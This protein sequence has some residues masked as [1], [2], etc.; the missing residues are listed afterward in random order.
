MIR[1]IKKFFLLVVL[2]LSGTSHLSASVEV[3]NPIHAGFS[4]T[5]DKEKVQIKAP[6][7]STTTISDET[8]PGGAHPGPIV[9]NW[10]PSD[11]WVAVFIPDKQATEI[12]VYDLKRGKQ[13][14]LKAT[15]L[16]DYPDW[17]ENEEANS[18]SVSASVLSSQS[19][20]ILILMRSFMVIF[21]SIL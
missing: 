10:D 6:S 8:Y 20:A 9:C 15:P 21:C 14:Q 2:F 12:H 18:T 3:Q 16:S 7:G 13:L 4:I 1:S 17:Y 11:T 19:A 5:A